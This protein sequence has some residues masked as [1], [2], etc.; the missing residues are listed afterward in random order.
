[1]LGENL[2]V[3]P[4]DK[5]GYSREVSFLKANGLPMTERNTKAENHTPLMFRLTGFHILNE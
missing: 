1:M 3:A 2:L 4:M 5:K